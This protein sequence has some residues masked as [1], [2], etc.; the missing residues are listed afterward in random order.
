MIA[1]KVVI[2]APS[3]NILAP[4]LPVGK[5]RQWMGLIEKKG[6]HA[7]IKLKDFSLCFI[8][9]HAPNPTV[10]YPSNNEN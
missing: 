1:Q 3:G 6:V 7:E 10:E 4:Q 5:P 2:L 9:V 8:L